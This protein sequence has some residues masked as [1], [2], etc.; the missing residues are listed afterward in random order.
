[1]R[2][3]FRIKKSAEIQDVRLHGKSISHPLVVYLALAKD[4]S[5]VRVAVAAGK[6]IGNAVQRN[7]AKRLLRAAV[8]PLLKEFRNGRD[9][10]L[11][12]RAETN[13]GNSESIRDA[14]RKMAIKTG[15]IEEL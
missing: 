13:Q 9:I 15:D 1:M 5:K 2:R 6:S 10:L 3:E 12:A 4:S 8:S 14:I 7:R 11:L